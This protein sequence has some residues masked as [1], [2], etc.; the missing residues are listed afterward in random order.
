MGAG[1]GVGCQDSEAGQA[2]RAVAV[3]G[4]TL[5]GAVQADGRAAHLLAAMTH[6]DGVVLTKREVGHKTNEITQVKPLLDPL[7][8]TARWSR[9]TRCTSSDIPPAIW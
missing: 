8:C 6:G 7:A 2:V 3:D 1:D 5:R 9:W 4:K